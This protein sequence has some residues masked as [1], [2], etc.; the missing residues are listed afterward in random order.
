MHLLFVLTCVKFTRIQIISRLIYTK[1]LTIEPLCNRINSCS[2]YTKIFG[3][4]LYHIITILL[5]VMLLLSP[6][7]RVMCDENLIRGIFLVVSVIGRDIPFLFLY[8]Q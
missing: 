5:W 8:Y 7:V 2:F 1:T 3:I 6:D 4:E